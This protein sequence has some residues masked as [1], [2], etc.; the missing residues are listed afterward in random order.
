EMLRIAARV[1]AARV[2]QGQGDTE[3]AITLYRDAAAVQDALPYMEPP[4]WYYPVQQ[5]LGAALLSQG[6]A[7]DA[8]AAF[9]EALKRSPNNGWAAFGLMRAAEARNDT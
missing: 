2:S 4:F 1:I 5:S 9:R 3:R 7:E 6:R 8:S